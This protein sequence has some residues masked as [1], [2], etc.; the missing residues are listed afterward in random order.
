MDGITAA[1]ATKK[2]PKLKYPL[3]VF[4]FVANVRLLRAERPEGDVGC[5]APGL[6]GCKLIRLKKSVLT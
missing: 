5:P 3:G 6:I 4:E 2:N 1:I